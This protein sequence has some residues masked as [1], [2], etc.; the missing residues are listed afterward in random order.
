MNIQSLVPDDLWEAIEPLLP[1]EPPK[2]K[3]GRPR[4][5]DRAALTGIV[6]VLQ[7]GIPWGLLPERAGLRQRDDL[8]AAA[9]RLA[10]GRG[11]G[12][13]AP[14]LSTGSVTRRPSTGAGP[15]ST[16]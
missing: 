3:G 9:A 11:L 2:P 10:G 7:T 16:A 8:L 13:A 15:A 5:P 4:V 14:R 1:K 12:A 6:F